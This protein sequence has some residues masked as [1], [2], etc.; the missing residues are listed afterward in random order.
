MSSKL[1]SSVCLTDDT[2]IVVAKKLT[3]KYTWSQSRKEIVLKKL[4]NGS[5]NYLWD[6]AQELNHD[7]LISNHKLAE[8]SRI[9]IKL[10]QRSNKKQLAKLV[11]TLSKTV[12][13]A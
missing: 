3:S 6:I 10:K 8:I 4:Q 12:K 11:E 2:G 9:I 1:L 5:L 7:Q 13:E